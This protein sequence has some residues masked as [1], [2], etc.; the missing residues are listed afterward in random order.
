LRIQNQVFI[1]PLTAMKTE[2][3]ECAVSFMPV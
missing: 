3:C 2:H 1:F